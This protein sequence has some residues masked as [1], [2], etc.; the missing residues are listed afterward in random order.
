MKTYFI[1]GTR[2]IPGSVHMTGAFIQAVEFDETKPIKPQ[3]RDYAEKIRAVVPA[4]LICCEA[5]ARC[6]SRTSSFGSTC[7][8][9]APCC[10]RLARSCILT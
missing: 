3:L 2:V 1:I 6:G 4:G 5:S 10:T 7:W 9:M 8:P